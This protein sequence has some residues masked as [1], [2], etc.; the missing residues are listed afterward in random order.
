MIYFALLA[1]VFCLAPIDT[2]RHR[3]V[4]L[5][6]TFLLLT[7]FLSVRWETGTD[8]DSYFEYFHELDNYRNFE[9]GYVLE[10][11]AIR[12]FTDNFTL[13]LF[14]NSTIAIIPIAMFIRNECKGSTTLACAIFYSYYYVITYFGS[15]RRIVA[16]ALCVLAA[17][18]LL[19]QRR[20]LAF[21]LIVAAACFHYS[22]MLC[23]LY[24]PLEQFQW[25]RRQA[26]RLGFWAVTGGMLLYLALPLLM[27]IGIFQQPLTR[28]AE[29]LIVDTSVEGYDK[30][31]LSVLSIAK[32]LLIIGFIAFSIVKNRRQASS[33]DVF[34]ANSYFLSFAIYLCSELV[35]GDIFKTFTIYFSIFEIALIPNLIM[36]YN[37]RSRVVLYGLFVA[38]LC[39]QTYSATFGN[40]FVE[41]YIP[42]RISPDL[43]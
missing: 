15:D 35:I 20:R 3:D 13:F 4:Y 8:W 30:S 37:R 41:L 9:I 25:S 10:N 21:A 19:E 27:S 6:V 43:S 22:A 39:Y 38:Y 23:M 26:W 32:R 12:L 31:T 1:I 11:E 40:P 34:F 5:S 28:A 18:Q 42:Y 7:V 16:I 14:I 29:Y 33:R 17:M 36:A 24:F 2:R